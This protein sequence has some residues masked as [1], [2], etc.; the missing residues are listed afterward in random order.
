VDI[1]SFVNGSTDAATMRDYSDGSIN[2][3]FVGRC[4]PNKRLEDFLSVT[5][6]LTKIMPRVRIMHVGAQ[7]GAELYF[8]I[9]RARA[10]AL[11]LTNFLDLGSVTQP[12]LNACYASASA[13]LCLSEHEGF[14]APLLEAMLHHVPVFALAASAV[15]ETLGG[16]GVLFEPPLD[17]VVAAETIAEVLS[18]EP[19]RNAIVA[20]QDA[21][22]E[23][24]RKRDLDGEMRALFAPVLA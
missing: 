20:R 18:N 8:G 1:D 7:T 14:C 15:P 5:Y 11:G 6:Y 17:Q 21:R 22:V 10:M 12:V 4:A 13:F 9:I 3:L 19:L 2:V 24:F 16:A 23:S